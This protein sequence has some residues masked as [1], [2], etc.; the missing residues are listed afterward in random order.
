MQ[1]NAVYAGIILQSI[2]DGPVIRESTKEVLTMA[3]SRKGGR[4]DFD[5]QFALSTIFLKR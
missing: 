4:L 1:H 5:Q 3:L 2:V